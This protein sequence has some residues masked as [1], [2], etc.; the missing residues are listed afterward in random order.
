MNFP[1]LSYPHP[2]E[3]MS[4]Y[5]QNQSCDPFT[6]RE[7]SCDLGNYVVY[8]INASSAHDIAS[9][10]QFAEKHNIRVAIKNTGHE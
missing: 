9:G 5:W 2:A 1:L 8:T 4:P 6:S 10:L 3:I 7:K